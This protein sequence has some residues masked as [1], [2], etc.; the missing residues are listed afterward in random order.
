MDIAGLLPCRRVP[1]AGRGG[2]RWPCPAW[3][4]AF[5]SLA[6]FC[7][8][9]LFCKACPG[10]QE[11]ALPES[12]IYDLLLLLT[13]AARRGQRAPQVWPQVRTALCTPEGS[14][15]GSGWSRGHPLPDL[16]RRTVSVFVFFLL[17][18]F[19][20]HALTHSLGTTVLFH[21]LIPSLLLDG[22]LG[23]PMK[24]SIY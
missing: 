2:Y 22:G 19:L 20:F 14:Q 11:T 1:G 6:C 3:T 17:L 10:L 23:N 24:T 8:L 5:L 9:Y 4:P 15:V 16:A 7:F 13:R 21:S 18:Y 12:W